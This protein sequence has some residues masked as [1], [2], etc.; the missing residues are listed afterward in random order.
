M[1]GAEHVVG[2]GEVTAGRFHAFYHDAEGEGTFMQDI[3]TLHD[4]EDSTALGINRLNQ[5]IGLSAPILKYRAIGG[6]NGEDYRVDRILQ[7]GLANP[8][9]GFFWE[10]G[11][12]APQPLTP[13]GNSGWSFPLD[14]ND[15]G[16]VV[17]AS[18]G[19]ATIW[20]NREPRDL[21]DL[22]RIPGVTLISADGIN[23]T[24]Q[25]V[26]TGV[27]S[28]GGTRTTA[29]LLDLSDLVAPS[30]AGFAVR[31]SR[32]KPDFSPDLGPGVAAAGP[33]PTLPWSGVDT[34]SLRFSEDV[35]VLQGDLEVTSAGGRQYSIA[36]FRYD[37]TGA[38][39]TATW[40]LSPAVAGDRLKL[41][42]KPRVTDRAGNALSATPVE[43]SVLAGDASRDGRVTG[44][45]VVRVRRLQGTMLGGPA[46]RGQ[47]YSPECDINGDG[48]INPLDLTLVRRQLSQGLPAPLSPAPLSPAPAQVPQA[49]TL[50]SGGQTAPS[51]T[52]DLFGST[53]IVP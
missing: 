21:D 44:V 10:P 8:G 23:N 50:A 36:D 53:E 19:K 7:M 46:V 38:A 1:N 48:R 12:A 18:N 41:T 4:G 40:K 15:S 52:R 39:F 11:Y 34:V 42:L 17:G 20:I 29:Y 26:A 25:I 33:A 32:W 9:V 47:R 43:F 14:L 22:V 35:D 37:A 31:G 6:K 51:A 45:D 30:V 24:G 27:P 28:D 16:V 3:G 5:V 2:T 49:G 13:L